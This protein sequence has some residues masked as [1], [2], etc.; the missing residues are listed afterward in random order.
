MRLMASS[1][2]ICMVSPGLV[3]CCNVSDQMNCQ[4]T[5]QADE[6]F[7]LTEIEYLK[8]IQHD[9]NI[10]LEALKINLLCTH[11][12]YRKLVKI[13]RYVSN[14]EQVVLTPYS[15]FYLKWRFSLTYIQWFVHFKV[16]CKAAQLV[17]FQTSNHNYGGM[18]KVWPPKN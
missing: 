1:A 2:Y 8:V 4:D 6:S 12:F 3:K 18:V 11:F 17:G 10:S 16:L 15:W 14:M 9:Y 7:S 13:F 5:A